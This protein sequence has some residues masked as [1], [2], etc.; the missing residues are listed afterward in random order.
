MMSPTEQI[1]SILTDLARSTPE[2]RAADILTLIAEVT[3][4]LR[5]EIEA[6]REQNRFL[7]NE[8]QDL[9]GFVNGMKKHV[10]GAAAMYGLKC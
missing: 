7:Q 10:E 5:M 9:R 1:T 8:V 3:A 2:Q 6:L 4:S